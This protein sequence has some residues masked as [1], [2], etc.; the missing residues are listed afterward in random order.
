ME[1]ICLFVF[2]GV[3]V[4]VA[5]A[6]P[7]RARLRLR[8]PVR[9]IKMA[10]AVWS[11]FPS[12]LESMTLTSHLEAFPSQVGYSLCRIGKSKFQSQRFPLLLY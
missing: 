7:S 3:L 8:C 6:W 2:A 11:T 9:I 10:V 1:S 4:Q 5:W 12:L